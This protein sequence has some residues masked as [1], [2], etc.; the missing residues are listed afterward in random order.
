MVTPVSLSHQVV[1]V[2][3]YIWGK[4]L[5]QFIPSPKPTHVGASDT[6]YAFFN[7]IFLKLLL[8]W[9]IICLLTEQKWPEML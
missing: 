7:Y 5:P 4:R 2:S 8:H 1:G 9:E 3:S 6:G